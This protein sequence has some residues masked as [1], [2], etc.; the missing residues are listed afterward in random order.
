[1]IKDSKYKRLKQRM[2][3]KISEKQASLIGFIIILPVAFVLFYKVSAFVNKDTVT[4]QQFVDLQQGEQV[5]AGFRRTHAKGSCVGGVFESNGA[6]NKYSTASVLQAGSF[7]FVGRF[8][9]AGNNPTAPDLKAPVRSLALSI[10]D[11]SVHGSEWRIAMNTPPVM[12]VAT[13]EAFYA[14]LKALA[15]NPETKQRDPSKISAFFADHPESKAFLEWKDTYIPATS[16]AGEIYN[17]INAF[18]LVDESHTQQA[19]RWQAVPL[20][21]AAKVLNVDDQ[22]PD[23]LQEQL[24]QMLKIAPVKFDLVFTL[25]TPEDDEANPTILWPTQRKTINAGTLS[26]QQYSVQDGGECANINFDPLVLPKGIKPSADPILRAR[27][28][29]Y[30]ESFRRRA[31]EVLLGE[32][33]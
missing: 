33:E 31:K 19:V 4:A 30:A 2:K 20:V 15:P 5:H 27:S 6:L 8:S 14:Q 13:P 17:S 7:P 22:N 29:A 28:S 10:K 23:A 24:A 18:Y 26:I 25:A 11:T 32:N 16:F 12:A 21:E 1:M 3:S 9:I